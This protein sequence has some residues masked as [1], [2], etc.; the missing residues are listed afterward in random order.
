MGE[1]TKYKQKKIYSTNFVVK[2]G[3]F[4]QSPREPRVVFSVAEQ[5]QTFAE[6]SRGARQFSSVGV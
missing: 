4:G 3:H 1:I 6:S 5:R 2:L